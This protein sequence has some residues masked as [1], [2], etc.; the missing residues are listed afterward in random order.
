MKRWI[1][2]E[3]QAVLY[4]SKEEKHVQHFGQLGIKSSVKVGPKDTRKVELLLLSSKCNNKSAS[5]H[6]CGK[7]R[8][9]R[10][11]WKQDLKRL[12]KKKLLKI[13]SMAYPLTPPYKHGLSV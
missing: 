12:L 13:L 8:T 6:H 2:E 9:S 5:V 7:V 10:D 11:Q 4:D 3:F 1:P